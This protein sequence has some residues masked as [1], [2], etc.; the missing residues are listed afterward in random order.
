MNYDSLKKAVLKRL[1]EGLSEKLYYHSVFHTRDVLRVCEARAREIG[2][3]EI[4]KTLL[5]TAAVL[6][7]AGFLDVLQEHEK[8]GAQIARDILPQYHYSKDQIEQVAGMIM[9]T[10]IP[11]SPQNQLERII[12]DADLDYLG[13][14]DFYTIGN[15]L[16]QEL[17]EMGIV[18]NIEEWDT[19]QIAFLTNH[20]YHTDISIR[21]RK[22]QK[23]ARLEELKK[24]WK[25]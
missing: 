15:F 20:N 23:I 14:D 10:K 13:R 22:C 11:Q 19:L 8:R 2:L 25:R 21:D 17:E 4:D 9:A 6:H 5:F 12:C 24:K 7:D 18:S 1:E 16:Y 3:S